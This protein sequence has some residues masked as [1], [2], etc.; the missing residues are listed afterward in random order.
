VSANLAPAAGANLVVEPRVA[1]MLVS[2]NSILIEGETLQAWAIQRRIFALTG[3]RALVAV[4]SG[5]LII[6]LRRLLGGFNLMDFR[7]QDLREVR[8]GVGIFG[9]SLSF[10]TGTPSDLCIASAHDRRLVCLG[11][12]KQQAREAYRVC[13]AEEQ[14]WREKRRIRELEEM[15]ARSGAVRISTAGDTFAPPTPGLQSSDPMQRL[16]SARQMLETK[17]ISDAEFE[18]IKARIVNQL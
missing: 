2:L 11:L 15:R 17:L 12:R 10:S 13:Q 7:F 9:A 14:A 8:I 4:T 3:R 18:S 1:E 6:M 5:R 16:Q